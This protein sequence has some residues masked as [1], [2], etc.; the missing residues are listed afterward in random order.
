MTE[1]VP[2][3][4]PAVAL[5]FTPAMYQA[6]DL[7]LKTETRRPL[8]AGNCNLT[9]GDFAA[10]DLS[11]GRADVGSFPVCGLKC[12]L[13]VAGGRRSVT[14]LPRIRPG[15]VL[16]ARQGQGGPGARR[17]NAAFFLHVLE[18]RATRLLEIT[19]SEA[20]AE[21]VEVFAPPGPWW[22]WGVPAAPLA[23]SRDE[24]LARAY[25]FQLEELGKK[26]AA[27]WR[28][29]EVDAEVRAREGRATARHNFAL[30]F[31]SINGPGTW[32]ENPWVWR[33][34]FRKAEP[35]KAEAA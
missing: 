27:L 10:L 6:L 2:R 7:D 9:R 1:Y 34:V 4:T 35:A 18:V 29:G 12:R 13:D 8:T 14:V 31:E 24:R 23:S 20:L 11:V 32:H 22:G 3:G 19:E 17:Q 26:R 16:W 30:L 15:V 33:Y 25:A 28:A 5:R 21:G